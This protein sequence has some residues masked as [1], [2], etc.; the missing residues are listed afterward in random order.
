MTEVKDIIESVL[1][2]QEYVRQCSHRV[3]FKSEC[4]ECKILWTE[5]LLITAEGNVVRFKAELA[6]LRASR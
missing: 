6:K 2:P 5:G 1:G 4:I 3:D